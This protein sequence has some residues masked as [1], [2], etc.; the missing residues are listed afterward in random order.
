MSWK[1]LVSVAIDGLICI[2]F[3]AVY[4]LGVINYMYMYLVL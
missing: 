4:L 3:C 1:V 2:A